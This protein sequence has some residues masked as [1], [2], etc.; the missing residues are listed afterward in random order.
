M[1]DVSDLHVESSTQ[2]KGGMSTGKLPGG[3][4]VTHIPTQLSVTVDKYRNMHENKRAAIRLAFLQ[5]GT[6][7]INAALDRLEEIGACRDQDDEAYMDI[8]Q[9]DWDHMR[10]LVSEFIRVMQEFS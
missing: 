2:P 4:K 3:V 5:G 9:E 1:F 8:P 7:E 10:R 6:Q